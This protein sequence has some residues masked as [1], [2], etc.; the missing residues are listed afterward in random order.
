MTWTKV[1]AVVSLPTLL[2][3]LAHINSLPFAYTLKSWWLLRSLVER[4]KKSNLDPEDLFTIVSQDQRCLWDDIDYN[5]H[6]VK[7]IDQL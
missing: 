3:G 4:A 7:Y 2:V 6:M 5:Q 1:I